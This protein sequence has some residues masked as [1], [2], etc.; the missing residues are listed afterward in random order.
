MLAGEARGPHQEGAAAA[1]AR[2]RQPQQ[3]ARRH[4]GDGR[5]A[6]PAVR[7]RHQQGGDRDRR[8]QEA[9][10]SDRCHRRHQLRSRRHRLPRSRATTTRA[11]P[12]RSTATSSRARPST[13][14]SAARRRP[15]PTSAHP[16][17]RRPRRCRQ[18]RS[19]KGIE[20]P[21]GEA[22]DL[23]RLPNIN[24]K[25]E[26]RLN[27]LGVYHFWQIADLEPEMA[28]ALDRAAQ[29]EG[30]HRADGWVAAAK[31]LVERKRPK[32]AQRSRRRRRIGLQRRTAP[33]T[34]EEFR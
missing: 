27:D 5:P 21:R 26:Q 34:R 19:F 24:N 7:D 25:L 16:R 17:R 10:H 29:A 14:S 8:G 3:V 30:P 32:T 33:E 22:D 31:K 18:C 15:A 4:Q 9:R 13:A 1:H 12:S 6:R 2:P 20:A 11:A 23:K 28:E